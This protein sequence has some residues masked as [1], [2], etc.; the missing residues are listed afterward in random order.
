MH[1]HRLCQLSQI[2][3]TLT[4][5][6]FGKSDRIQMPQPHVC[7]LRP[8][9]MISADVERRGP[10]LRRM[11]ACNNNSPLRSSGWLGKIWR[12]RN[13]DEWDGF[14]LRQS[15]RTQFGCPFSQKMHI[16]TRLCSLKNI[17][18][19]RGETAAER[20]GLSRRTRRC[21]DYV[22]MFKWWLSCTEHFGHFSDVLFIART[23]KLRTRLFSFMIA[24]C[25][26]QRELCVCVSAHGRLNSIEF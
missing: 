23:S 1:S 10:V 15:I 18:M 3:I 14:Q 6:H 26:R 21:N 20:A 13:P 16:S 12:E 4:S 11:N 19:K 2:G 17:W 24:P 22:E 7:I 9:T 8:C 5:R 25:S